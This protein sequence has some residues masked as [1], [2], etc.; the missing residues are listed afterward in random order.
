VER[1]KAELV[2]IYERDDEFE[3][4]QPF[5]DRTIDVA[6]PLAAIVEVVWKDSPDLEQS[7]IELIKAISI[8]RKDKEHLLEDVRILGVLKAHAAS[9]SPLVRTASE[10]AELDGLRGTVSEY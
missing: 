7:R 2:E 6:Q 4:L 5:R 10:L 3:Y 9:N 8:T 1:H